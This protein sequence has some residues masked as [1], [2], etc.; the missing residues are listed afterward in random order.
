MPDAALVGGAAVG[1][2]LLFGAGGLFHPRWSVFGPVVFKGPSDRPQV[3]VTF[4]DGPHEAYTEQIAALLHR[5]GARA[6]FFCIGQRLERRPELA[7]ALHRAGHGLGN[8]TYRHNTAGDLF[9]ASA[10]K[11]DL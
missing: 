10:L 2:G 3:A 4:D 1:A 7:Q 6:T 11:A 5:Y 9:S 8:H